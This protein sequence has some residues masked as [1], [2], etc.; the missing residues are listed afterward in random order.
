MLGLQP[1]H[2]RWRDSIFSLGCKRLLPY[3]DLYYPSISAFSLVLAVLAPNLLNILNLKA[4]DHGAIMQRDQDI[5]DNI[6]TGIISLDED[7]IV[8]AINAA[9]QALLEVSASRTIGM[10]AAQ[11]VLQP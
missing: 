7:L 8:I 6:S 11:L 10:H 2:P 1:D 4:V 5:L 3:S 9:G